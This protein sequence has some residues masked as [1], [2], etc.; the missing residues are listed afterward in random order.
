MRTPGRIGLLLGLLWLLGLAAGTASGAAPS[1]S[2][3]ATSTPAVVSMVD[4]MAVAAAFEQG[5][6]IGKSPPRRAVPLGAAPPNARPWS[7]SPAMRAWA[8]R[9][10]PA[11]GAPRERL[12]R[13][14]RALVARDGLRVIS[15]DGRSDSAAEVFQARRADCVGFA[16]L[17]AGLARSLG[18]DA[19]FVDARGAVPRGSTLVRPG[20]RLREGHVAVSVRDGAR[21]WIADHAGLRRATDVDRPLGDDVAAALLASNRGARHLLAGRCDAA[22]NALRAAVAAAPNHLPFRA[23]LAAAERCR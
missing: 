5:A 4:A 17:L 13:L 23:N 6:A 7:V 9:H 20:L 18:L 15:R 22:R 10:V 14:R 16:Y 19:R 11:D 8:R 1:W 21:V 2:P 3:G 12:A